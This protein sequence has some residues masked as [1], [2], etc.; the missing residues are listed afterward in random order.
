PA[1]VAEV[2]TAYG[3]NGAPERVAHDADQAAAAADALGYP[4]ALKLVSATITHKSDVGGVILALEDAA[5]VRE[6]YGVLERRLSDLGRA[7]EFEGALVQRMIGAAYEGAIGMTL[8]PQFGPLL[9]AGLGGTL[10]EIHKDVAFRLHPLAREDAASMVES[11]RSRPLFDGY[12][13]AAAADRAAFVDAIL[14]VSALVGDLP[15]I[16][17]LDLNPVAVLAPGRG[18]IV[19][20]ARIRVGAA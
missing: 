13:A 16:V 1:A 11:L 14:R 3:L 12:R 15:E 9:M 18:A 8:D 7:G 6:A 10:L 5:S 17:E 20:D 2:L 19:V 4:V